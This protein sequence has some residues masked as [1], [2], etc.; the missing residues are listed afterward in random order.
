MNRLGTD[1]P[2]AATGGR[3]A[4]IASELVTFVRLGDSVFCDPETIGLQDVLCGLAAVQPQR[5]DV[6]AVFVDEADEL[7]K[8][9]FALVAIAKKTLK[10]DQSLYT[11]F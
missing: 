8:A 1:K 5:G 3:Y 9:F 6:A 11:I 2:S 7:P 10:L 4:D